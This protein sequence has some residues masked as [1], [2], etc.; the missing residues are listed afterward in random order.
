MSDIRFVG[1]MQRLQIKKG[2]KFVLKVSRPLTREAVEKF[3][4]IWSKFTHG[5]TGPI[6]ILEPGMELGV[7][8]TIPEK[9]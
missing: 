1:D 4:E 9:D 6:L 2:D 5:E 8:S 7:V 3:Q